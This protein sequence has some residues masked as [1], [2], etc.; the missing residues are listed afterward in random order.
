MKEFLKNNN[1]VIIIIIIL[2]NRIIT[3]IHKLIIFLS[4]VYANLSVNNVQGSFGVALD[5]RGWCT[6]THA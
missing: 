2:H 6:R 5:L 1:Y 4:L 3:T